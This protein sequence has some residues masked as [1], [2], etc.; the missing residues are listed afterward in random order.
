MHVTIEELPT[1]TYKMVDKYEQKHRDI[2]LVPLSRRTGITEV[3]STFTAD[4]ARE[5]AERCLYCHI[6]PIYDG[7][8]MHPMQSMRGH[9]SRALPALH[10]RR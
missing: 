5:Q 3:E 1:D 7:A 6:H 9:L 4:D 10:A 2:P 8:E